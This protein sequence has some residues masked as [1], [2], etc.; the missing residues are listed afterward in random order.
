[1]LSGPL[2]FI[3]ILTTVT[4]WFLVKNVSLLYFIKAV[5]NEN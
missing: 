4:W 5:V 1:M 3:C 2:N